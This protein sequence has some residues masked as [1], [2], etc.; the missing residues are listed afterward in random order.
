MHRRRQP[1]PSRIS[2]SVRV[3]LALSLLTI[4]SSLTASLAFAQQEPPPPDCSISGEFGDLVFPGSATDGFSGIDSVS[5]AAGSENLLLDVET[6][7]PGSSIAIFTVTVENRFAPASGRVVAENVA[8]L[9]CSIP[10]DIPRAYPPV[11][12]NS[13]GESL[14][15]QRKDGSLYAFLA[16]GE[17]GVH[18]Y[19]VTEP[20]EPEFLST[21]VPDPGDCPQVAGYPDYYGDAVKIVQGGDL[22]F[23]SPL[24]NT[25]IALFAAGICGLI[26]VDI[27]EPT[28]PDEI[29]TLAVYPSP[30]WDEA[31]DFFIDIENETGTVYVASFWGGLRIF[32]EVDPSVNPIG[33]GEIASFGADDPAFG[34]AIDLDVEAQ[35]RSDGRIVVHVLTDIGMRTIDVSDPADPQQIGS[36]EFPTGD[37]IGGEGMTIVGNRAFVA[38]WRGGLLVLDISDPTNPTEIETIQ[39]NPFSAF[40]SVT[41]NAA[42]TRLYAAEGLNGVRT[43]RIN[44]DGLSEYFPSDITVADPSWAWSVTE[45]DRLLY[46]TYGRLGDP[47]TGGFQIFEFT[48]DLA[49]GLGFEAALLLPPLLWLR[50]RRRRAARAS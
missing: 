23:E 30:S 36:F 45:R 15:L 47:L 14:A 21:E 5:L 33:F 32:G 16:A 41:T 13:W 10:I 44:P 37:E 49:C 35:R 6:F 28:I 19:D 12:A 3:A 48:E 24:F 25:D 8:G 4:V 29:E 50:S 39:P 22:P 27:T 20:S 46:V 7:D 2:R 40:F 9:S 26:I 43:F 38:L 31:V 34:A 42:G 18:I 17:D 11:N 1:H